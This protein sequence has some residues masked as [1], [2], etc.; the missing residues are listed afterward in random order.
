MTLAALFI[1]LLPTGL[2]RPAALA[3]SILPTLIFDRRKAVITC[4]SVIVVRISAVGYRA[5]RAA[6]PVQCVARMAT[7]ARPCI[8]FFRDAESRHL[9]RTRGEATSSSIRNE[10]TLCARSRPAMIAG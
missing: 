1:S 4:Q 10:R 2:F 5:S 9:V 8:E 3:M 7:D 6:P